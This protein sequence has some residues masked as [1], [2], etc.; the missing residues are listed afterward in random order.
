MAEQTNP[1]DEKVE[2]P[3][4]LFLDMTVTFQRLANKFNCNDGQLDEV[5][6]D[7]AYFHKL[8]RRSKFVAEK[9]GANFES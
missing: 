9:M 5:D 1:Q 8:A 7:W 6:L 4:D 3:T 2:I